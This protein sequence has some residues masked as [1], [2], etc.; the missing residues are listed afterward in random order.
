[1][2]YHRLGPWQCSPPPGHKRQAGVH[3]R[4]NG[5]GVRPIILPRKP[6]APPRPAPRA[7][8]ECPV[9]YL[10]RSSAN[11]TRCCCSLMPARAEATATP[12]SICR[13]AES[14]NLRVR[15]RAAVHP[16]RAGAPRLPSGAVHGGRQRPQPLWAFMPPQGRQ[17]SPH[18]PTRLRLP[19][20]PPLFNPRGE[21]LVCACLY[22]AQT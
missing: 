4:T 11:S 20:P 19:G 6:L 7:S 22:D 3:M 1:M 9:A 16:V 21:A 17:G 5:C 14:V 13:S 15:G 2:D 18:V 10:S 12:P 8:R